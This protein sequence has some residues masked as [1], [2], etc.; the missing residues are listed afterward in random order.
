MTT[1]C[2]LRY[3]IL[4][5]CTLRRQQATQLDLLEELLTLIRQCQ[6]EWLHLTDPTDATYKPEL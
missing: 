1:F 4:S 6:S 5:S 2:H 3:V